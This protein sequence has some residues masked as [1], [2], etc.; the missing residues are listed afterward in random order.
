[1]WVTFHNSRVRNCFHRR[2]L[3]FHDFNILEFYLVFESQ[4]NLMLNVRDG[5]MRND[6]FCKEILS[7]SSGNPGLNSQK[8]VIF[9]KQALLS[10]EDLSQLNIT[11]P[12]EVATQCFFFTVLHSSEHMHERGKYLAFNQWMWNAL[13]LRKINRCILEMHSSMSTVQISTREVRIS[14]IKLPSEII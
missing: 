12:P 14:P 11:D 10:K 7:S 3:T 6:A 4:S 2:A 9:I 8:Q 13:G 5:E 1:M